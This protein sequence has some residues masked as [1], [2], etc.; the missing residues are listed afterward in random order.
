M[1]QG[2]SIPRI[3]LQE[4]TLARM[5]HHEIQSLYRFR[6]RPGLG[7]EK[8]VRFISRNNWS[9]C[10]EEWSIRRSILSWNSRSHRVISRSRIPV[11]FHP[12]SQT[13]CFQR[14][15][16]EL[17]A[18]E[19]RFVTCWPLF[20]PSEREFTALSPQNIDTLDSSISH[21]RSWLKAW[22]ECNGS[23]WRRKS[24]WWST[25]ESWR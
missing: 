24:G 23:P 3:S 12:Y 13:F 17:H 9:L 20:P 21:H 4:T 10:S 16:A 6:D 14:F 25:I 22:W 19:H 15:H 5:A 1:R 2:G 11:P 18:L 7:S 8:G